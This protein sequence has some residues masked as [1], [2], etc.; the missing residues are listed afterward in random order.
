MRAALAATWV[1]GAALACAGS[2]RAAEDGGTRSPLASGVGSRALALGGAF[3]GIAEG[4]EALGWNPAGLARTPRTGFEATYAE[5][6]AIDAR[7]DHAA[8]VLP[9]WRWGSVAFGIHHI[10]VSDIDARDERNAPLGSLSAG[11]SE[12][13]VGYARPMGE[14]WSF[15]AAL[16]L[17]NQSVADVNAS[18]LGADVGALYSFASGLPAAPAWVRS[19]SAG[20]AVRNLIVP[21]MRLDQESVPDPR[22]WR[23]GLAWRGELPGDRPLILALDCDGSDGVALRPHLGVELQLHPLF[24]LRGGFDDGRMTAGAGVRWHDL[25]MNYGYQD[26]STVSVHR[27]GITQSF[28]PTTAERREAARRADEL[29]LQ[30]RLEREFQ[31]RRTEQ[32]DGLLARAEEARAQGDF[33]GA[34]EQLAVAATLDSTD[35]RTRA[36]EARCQRELGA[37]LERQGDF[38]AASIAFQRTL[39]LAPADTAAANGAKRCRETLDRQHARNVGRRRALEAAL[40]ALARGDLATARAGFAA[41]VAADSTD[42]ESRRMLLRADQSIARRAEAGRAHVAARTATEA[43]PRPT[44]PA[45]AREAQ[46]W[47]RRGMAAMSARHADE[48]VRDW[49][50]AL[51]LDPSHREAARG[52]NREYLVRG[53]DAYAAGRLEEAVAF[54]EKAKRADP[55]DPRAA[56]FLDKARERLERSRAILGDER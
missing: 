25:E 38:T 15:G 19:L 27:I 12:I 28:G 48:A 51:S 31:H 46:D 17:Q 24:A 9:T 36:L 22:V 56:G 49:E 21:S 11:E 35:A 39:A 4:P 7:E 53:M 54:W 43:A 6:S 29:D 23:T 8:F 40:D 34:L 1:L 45:D 52:L 14:A 30:A 13:S 42:A 50:M 44:S 47:F 2:P 18:A 10:G 3:T 20:L 32:L 5:L 41:L 55:T 33:E 16:K 37:S 26:L